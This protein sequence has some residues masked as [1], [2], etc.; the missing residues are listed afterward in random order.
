VKGEHDDEQLPSHPYG[1]QGEHYTPYQQSRYGSYGIVHGRTSYQSLL[2]KVFTLLSFSMIAAGIG[3]FA[4]LQLLHTGM[5]IFLFPTIMLGPIALMIT[6]RT[7]P[8]ATILNLS[9]LYLFVFIS[10]IIIS[11]I[12]ADYAATGAIHAI[13]EALALTGILTVGLGTVAWTA[14]RTLGFLG[15]MLG[16]R[17]LT[18]KSTIETNDADMHLSRPA[19]RPRVAQKQCP[20]TSETRQSH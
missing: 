13:Y 12:S 11:T 16:R 19:L 7:L 17:S 15:P 1:H 18:V 8:K 3:Q 14:K 9:L 4:G 6:S 20:T 2:S 5:G 10:G